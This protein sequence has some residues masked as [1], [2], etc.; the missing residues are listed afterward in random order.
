[1]KKNILIIIS[2]CMLLSG[3]VTRDKRNVFS[4]AYNVER[5]GT[6]L[7]IMKFAAEF[8]KLGCDRIELTK[9]FTIR[10]ADK[11]GYYSVGFVQ[12]ESQGTGTLKFRYLDASDNVTADFTQLQNIKK[13]EVTLSFS[14]AGQSLEMSMVIS[15]PFSMNTTHTITGSGKGTNPEGK[16]LNITFSNVNINKIGPISGKLI[17][18]DVDNAYNGEVRFNADYTADGEINLLANKIAAIHIGSDTKSYY[19]DEDDGEKH[20]LM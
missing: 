15:N 2:C 7:Q 11:S 17:F 19:I 8:T 4:P 1:M 20:L 16:V 10:S 14:G 3:C 5:T 13:V 6:Y 9:D 12:V 18:I